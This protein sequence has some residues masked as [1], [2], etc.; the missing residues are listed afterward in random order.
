MSQ[1][2]ACIAWKA[3]LMISI[4]CASSPVVSGSMLLKK[5]TLRR[6][7]ANA[8]NSNAR[9]QRIKAENRRRNLKKKHKKPHIDTKYNA[10]MSYTCDQLKSLWK[11]GGKMP[12]CG[13]CVDDAYYYTD[14]GGEDGTGTGGS[15]DTNA[16]GGTDDT[17]TNGTT[18]DDGT[19]SGNTDDDTSTSGATDDDTSTGGATDDETESG[20]T[21]DNNSNDDDIVVETNE[22]TE[23]FFNISRCET[24]SNYWLWD[25]SLSCESSQNLTTCECTTAA[26]LM[27]DGD[28]SC[29]DGTE[30]N[31]Y[32]PNNCEICD[33]C[34][35]LLGC[36]NTKPNTSSR[37]IV[38]WNM[39]IY[40]IAAVGAVMLGAVATILHH[41]VG[42]R[43][44]LLANENDDNVWLAPVSD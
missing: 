44:P 28:L 38:Q 21:D 16:N 7:E 23:N 6:R 32:C 24:Y 40:I 14:D 2:R 10:C 15:D 33:T 8:S 36:K 29:P 30:E 35:Q 27:N 42:T 20:T 26:Q 4:L 13:G 18:D 39:L 3:L 17:N 19:G 1:I 5:T 25:L 11:F 41:R 34:M 12:S 37:S 9:S 22:G 43:E 31:P